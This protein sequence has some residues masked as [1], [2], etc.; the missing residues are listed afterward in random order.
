MSA[1]C[2][3]SRGLESGS[4][5]AAGAATASARAATAAA[6]SPPDRLRLL[7]R[8]A[9][10]SPR[11]RPPS[12]LRCRAGE[13]CP[14]VS[15]S[16]VSSIWS[17]PPRT[18]ATD[19]PGVAASLTCRSGGAARDAG[20]CIGLPLRRGPAQRCSA[21]GRGVGPRCSV[22]RAPGDVPQGTACAQKSFAAGTSAAGGWQRQS[23][24][25]AATGR[26]CAP[27]SPLQKMHNQV[28]EL[29]ARRGR[30][31]KGP[32]RRAGGCGG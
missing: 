30:A 26:T 23:G 3:R 2:T 13:A 20:V 28:S 1:P 10:P 6:C 4:A 18:A 21:V 27:A 25:Q 32:P 22:T 5:A 24:R 16:G 11:E 9:A 31:S 8:A 29:S 14:G 7:S 12:W 19:A 17:S 15:N